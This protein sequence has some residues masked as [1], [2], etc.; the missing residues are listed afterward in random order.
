MKPGQHMKTAAHWISMSAVAAALILTR[1]CGHQASSS[2]RSDV[3]D[4]RLLQ[5]AH[6]LAHLASTPDERF[7]SDQAIRVADHELDLAYSV[8]LREAI[9]HPGVASPETRELAAR[10][11]KATAQV[12]ADHDQ[13]NLFKAQ[14]PQTKGSQQEALQQQLDILEAQFELDQDE[15]QDAQNDLQSAGGD[16]ATAIQRQRENHQRTQEHGFGAPSADAPVNSAEAGYDAG[17]LIAQVA[18]WYALNRKATP[19]M[20]VREGAM[21]GAQAL[22]LQHEVKES[23][24]AKLAAMTQAE[25]RGKRVDSS[26]SPDVARLTALRLQSATQRTI[27]DIAKRIEDR[28]DI[29]GIYGEWIRFIQARTRIAMVGVL[30][31]ALWMLLILLAA[32]KAARAVERRMAKRPPEDPR[33]VN[34]AATAGFGLQALGVVLCLMVIFGFPQQLPT[35]IFGIVGAGVTVALK[36]FAGVLVDKRIRGM[37]NA[38]PKPGATS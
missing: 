31:S 36:D 33:L 29:S 34:L 6:S 38:Y 24:A 10:V 8:A 5:T 26:D 4:E 20:Q 18:A 37:I 21:A 27:T 15:L 28:R 35:A 32:P 23:E 19:L 12:K 25:P 16:M 13:I 11:S 7:F 30:R 3:V 1:D 14:I 17:N 2:S 9:G 22:T